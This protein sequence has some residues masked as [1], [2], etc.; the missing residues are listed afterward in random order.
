[1]HTGTFIFAVRALVTEMSFAQ[2]RVSRRKTKHRWQSFKSN[3][4]RTSE[5]GPG[6]A[7]TSRI[8]SVALRGVFSSK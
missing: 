8:C 6:G 5:F 1:M 7:A 3:P 2:L 4:S